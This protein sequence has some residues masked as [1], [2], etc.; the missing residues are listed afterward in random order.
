MLLMIIKE[1]PPKPR[2]KPK[3]H[4]IIAWVVT[5]LVSILPDILLRE[6]GGSVPSWIFWAKVGLTLVVLVVSAI[7][8][9]LRPIRLFL[10][11][12]LVL[13][14]IGWGVSWFYQAISYK[15]WLVK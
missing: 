4:L 11:V 14:L 6:L 5:L 12:L 1:T 3:L 8:L 2:T 9:P 10:A 7:W 13:Q 15:H